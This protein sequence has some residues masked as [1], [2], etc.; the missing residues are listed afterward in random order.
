MEY[1]WAV[2]ST[3]VAW[4]PLSY[5]R[6]SEVPCY[7]SP[8]RVVLKKEAFQLL[9]LEAKE[10][11]DVVINAPSE[12]MFDCGKPSIM[13]IYDILRSRSWTW[14]KINKAR[15]EVIQYVKGL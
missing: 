1:E 11:I 5:Q 3:F 2:I 8:E 14:S 9:S 4:N 12:A 10:L 15:S 7:D 13:R 6:D